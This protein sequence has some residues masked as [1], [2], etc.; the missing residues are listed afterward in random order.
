MHK[1]LWQ[2]ATF[3]YFLMV[4]FCCQAVTKKFHLR[5][6]YETD[7]NKLMQSLGSMQ[8]AATEKYQAHVKAGSIRVLIAPHAGYQYAG[9]V[10]TAVYALAAEGFFERI[11][12]MGPDHAG[13][14]QGVA[15]PSSTDFQVP[16]GVL[17]VDTKVTKAV[18][19]QRNFQ[20]NDA[21]FDTEH[22][23]EMQLP[24]IHY[25]F[26]HAKIVPLIVGSLTCEQAHEVARV[27]KR[28][29]NYKTLV[30][31]STDFIHY[32]PRYEYT[33]F[34]DELVSR[35]RA[36]DGQLWQLIEN[37]KCTP[38]ANFVQQSGATICG[39][40]PLKILLSLLEMDTFGA[41]EPRLVAYD[42][43]SNTDENAVSYV[44]G[45]FT[46][47][48]LASLPIG[49]QLTQQEQRGLSVQMHDTLHHLFDKDFD[50][51][52][53]YP[54][55]SYGVTRKRGAFVTLM[56]QNNGKS[57][58]R[59]CIGRIEPD[60]PLYQTVAQV[61]QDA[62]LHDPRFESTQK[63]ELPLISAKLAILSPLKKVKSFKR[64]ALG[65]DGVV[66]EADGGSALFLPEVATEFHWT[67]EQMLD[68]LAQKA[69]LPNNAWR[70]KDAVFKLFRTVDIE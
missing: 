14:M 33:P 55:L 52:R 50:A 19:T 63:D 47:Q 20:T 27:L 48:R 57:E 2:T 18:R 36:L 40:N 51:T 43:S 8:Q 68:Q 70:N 6:W 7:Q 1:R 53:Y 17:A 64:I 58:L 4:A 35:V 22:S 34:T 11:I 65:I 9:T 30:V 32:G 13:S 44:G 24:L 62:A 60:K 26:P 49:Y 69:G 31:V 21:L 59:G 39:V 56:K 23:I 54:F 41:V 12:I 16:I 67:R 61:T 45:L 42:R 15:V 29:I 66:L 37:K 46:Q 10:A 38:F 5:G 25:Y 3:G 28:Y